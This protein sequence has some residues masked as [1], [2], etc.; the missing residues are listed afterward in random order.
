MIIDDMIDTGGTLVK[1]VAMIKQMGA[2]RVYCFATHGTFFIVG[3]FS[4]NALTNLENS[5]LDEVLVTN[6]I[7]S[8]EQEENISKIKRLSIGTF[9]MQQI[10]S[11]RR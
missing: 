3:L 5:L 6:T 1:A 8:K 11:R 9:F 2:K 10:C 4:G 7:P